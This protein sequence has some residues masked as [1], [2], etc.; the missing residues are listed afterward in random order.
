[1]LQQVLAGTAEGIQIT[2]P[3]LLVAAVVAEVAIA[4]VLLSLQLPQRSGPRAGPAGR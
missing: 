1:M 3:F 2:P 4:M